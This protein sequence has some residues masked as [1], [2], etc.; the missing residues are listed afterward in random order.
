MQGARYEML[1]QAFGGEGS[2]VSDPES[3]AK[4]LTEALASKKPTLIN[5]LIDP[6][7]GT[8]SGHIGN[9]NPRSAIEAKS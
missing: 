3:L 4:A 1:C 5:C 8:E 9:L 2:R 7:A 6:K